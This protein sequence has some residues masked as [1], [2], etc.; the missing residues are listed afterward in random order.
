MINGTYSNP[1]RFG[2]H[3]SN[4]MDEFIGAGSYEIADYTYDREHPHQSLTSACVSCHMY[5]IGFGEPGG[6]VYGHN[7]EANL[8]ACEPCHGTQTN[9]DINSFQTE[10]QSKLDSLIAL[11]CVDPDSI[12]YPSLTTTEERMAGWA[13]KFVEND[14]S[15]GVHNP[16]Y[17]MSL[18]D[19]AIDFLNSLSSKNKGLAQK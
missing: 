11:I 16:D 7:F 10:V 13:Y 19:N 1:S 6:P 17:T 14:G 8:L 9:F 3:H 18:L 5:S 12:G 4:Q 15:L 2:S